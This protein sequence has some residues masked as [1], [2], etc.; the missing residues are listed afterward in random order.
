MFLDVSWNLIHSTH[1]VFS[2]G[3][4]PEMASK[5]EWWHRAFHWDSSR[6]RSWGLGEKK[7]TPSA[8]PRQQ[9]DGIS[10]QWDS[11][12]QSGKKHQEPISL[13]KKQ[14]QMSNETKLWILTWNQQEGG[15]RHSNHSYMFY[16]QI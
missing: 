12:W 14:M 10:M 4:S 5:L 11:S 13:L 2:M 3:K 16:L 8:N 9:E 6:R 15:I 7:A 1:Y